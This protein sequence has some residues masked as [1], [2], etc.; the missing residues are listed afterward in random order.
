MAV[1]WRET[2]RTGDYPDGLWFTWRVRLRPFR[3]ATYVAQILA[4]RDRFEHA[5]SAPVK[6][7]VE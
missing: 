3:T 2:P 5:R 4:W 7:R 6:V 1:R